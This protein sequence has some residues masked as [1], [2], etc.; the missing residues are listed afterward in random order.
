MITEVASLDLRAIIFCMF[1]LVFSLLF[2]IRRMEK[3][4]DKM[5]ELRANGCFERKLNERQ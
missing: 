2:M 3:L 5:R 4:E 1:C